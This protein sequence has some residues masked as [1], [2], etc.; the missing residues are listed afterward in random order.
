MLAPLRACSLAIVLALAGCDDATPSATSEPVPEPT[1]PLRAPGVRGEVPDHARVA[2]YWIDARLDAERHEITG[3]LRLAW[4]NRTKRS[5]DRLP[6]HLYMNGFRAEDTAWMSQA[7]GRHRGQKF[8]R[9]RWGFV[10]VR[11][12]DQIAQPIDEALFVGFENPTPA[13][14]P[15]A[16]AE[17]DEPSTMSVAL[18]RPLGPGES[19]VLEIEFVTR[20]P[21]V[22]ARTGYYDDFHM[23]GQW[24]PKIAVLEEA[25]GWQAHT[26]GLYSEFYADFGNYEVQLDVP[27]EM[28][29]GAT[30]VRVGE[31]AVEGDETRTRLRY[32]AAMVHDFAWAADPDFVEHWGEVDGIRVRQLLQ[33]EHAGDGQAHLDALAMTITSMQERFGPYPWSTITVVHPPEGA[34]GAGGMEYPTF[35]TTS[36]IADPEWM[37]SWLITERLSGLFTT[38][39]EF[40]HQ[41]FQ[42]L[43]ASNEHAQPWLDEGMNT[44]SNN[45][46]Y[47]DGH[48]GDPWVVRVLGHEL[49]VVD[50][51]MISLS[52]AADHGAIDRPADR[53]SPL[54]D[55]AYGV[56]TYQKTAALFMTLRELVGAEPFDA[57]MRAY[58]AH[59]RFSHPTGAELERIL[60]ATILE[61]YRAGDPES[62]RDSEVRLAG[63]G[64]PGSVWFDLREFL[65]EGLRGASVVDVQLIE[66]LNRPKLGHGGWHRRADESGAPERSPLEIEGR[67]ALDRVFGR[68]PSEGPSEWQSA[69]TSDTWGKPIAE[70]ADD[71]VEGVVVVQ[72]RGDFV[73]PVEVLVE[74]ADGSTELRLWDGRAPSEPLLFAGRVV[75][76]V[77]DPRRK[78]HVAPRR[79][80]DAAWSRERAEDED[81]ALTG[82]LGDVAQAADLAALGGL[83]L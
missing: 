83:G 38:V 33:P 14:T 75:R 68:S 6:F 22:F 12:V 9:E 58:A 39:H 47:M 21:Q 71:E 73:V 13:G 61:H 78:L 48:G 74:F 25:G 29:V 42:G 16:F 56:L 10:E 15:L 51:G 49:S 31:A 50:I 45:L 32:R 44:L 53:F 41:Y 46:A 64:E 23:A 63:A 34:E 36:D 24:Y 18:A 40:G 67:R 43:F 8:A 19:I 57:G 28:V 72:R 55:D 60:I 7:R 27:A 52:M 3:T 69:P 76:A 70:L 59:A 35:I 37:P 66:V 62:V 11:R 79:L 80:D 54:Q 5:V 2:D 82:W 26:F 81:D 1:D 17:D 20:L 77:L 30:G 4:R 65:D